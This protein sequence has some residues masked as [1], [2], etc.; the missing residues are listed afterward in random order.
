VGGVCFLVGCIVVAAVF[1]T[2]GIASA[3]GG[4]HEGTFGLTTDACAG[5]HRAH[6]AQAAKLLKDSSQYDLCMSC[7]ADGVG[8]DTNVADGTYYGTTAGDNGYGLRGGGFTTALMNTA[9]GD[10]GTTFDED[11]TPVAITSKHTIGDASTIAWGA[12]V[13]GDANDS[14]G[15]TMTLECGSCHNP[16]GNGH[17]RILKS[18]PGAPSGMTLS[19]VDVLDE[20]TT[21]YTITYDGNDYRDL[22]QYDS[23]TLL[24]MSNWC[25]QCHTQYLATL[26]DASTANGTSSVFMYRHTTEGGGLAGECMDCHVA[27]GTPAA[28]GTYSDA[29]AW[30]GGDAAAWQAASKTSRLLTIDNR[31]VCVRC[32]DSSVLA[33]N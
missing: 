21:K 15:K 3:D 16:H 4:P 10:V 11:G 1:A 18:Q 30:P 29:V 14:K 5:C 23:S 7:H 32:H 22:T 24:Q 25:A 9:M 13:S 17:Y 2:A 6:T 19:D 27:H 31:G 8:A 33:G 20:A 26:G 28:M 12:W